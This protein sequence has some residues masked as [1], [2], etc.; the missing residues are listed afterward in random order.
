MEQRKDQ[1]RPRKQNKNR[2]LEPMEQLKKEKTKAYITPIGCKARKKKVQRNTNSISN[3]ARPTR[4]AGAE[5]EK[6]KETEKHK[7]NW[8]RTKH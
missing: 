2:Q 5:K 7:L 4:S 1:I 3:Q 6:K 8:K